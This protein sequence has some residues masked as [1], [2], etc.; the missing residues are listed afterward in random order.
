M[1][2]EDKPLVSIITLSY[3]KFDYI[4][5][6][7]KSVLRQDYPNIQYIVSDDG[8]PNA[9]SEIIED[10][11]KNHAGKNI[12]DFLFLT[13]EKNVGTV[14]NLNQA[15]YKANGKYIIN[16]SADDVFYSTQVVS[17]IVENFQKRKCDMLGSL[18]LRCDKNLKPI[19]YM[20]TKFYQRRILKWNTSQKQYEA[21][22]SG[23]FF[24]MASG[25][26]LSYTR[27]YWEK[28]PFDEEYVLW[29]DGPFIERYL[30]N[31]GF[32]NFDYTIPAI[33]YR[34]GG[35]STG[36]VVNPLLLKDTQKY[37]VN[38]YKK[39]KHLL[40]WVSTQMLESHMYSS[41]DNKR[42]GAWIKRNVKYFY[43][44]PLKLYYLIEKKMVYGIE[45]FLFKHGFMKL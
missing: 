8:S 9:P 26:V 7:I 21:F 41:L 12:K 38:V 36:N 40:G 5:D 10:Y 42:F 43:I 6:T 35:I 27:S 23:R 3:K 31:G 30:R 19:R 1:S 20:P 14:K 22:V 4:Y 44:A 29:E 37:L 15:I 17:R 13:R 28:N 16:L 18:R 34:E 39:H 2:I 25:S 33:Y 32:L 45:E 11:V 24:E